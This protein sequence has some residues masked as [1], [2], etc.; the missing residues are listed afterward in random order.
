M[1]WLCDPSDAAD[2]DGWTAL[3][4]L[5]MKEGEFE[6][7]LNFLREAYVHHPGEAKIK[8]KMAVC[9]LKL[10]EEKLAL[11]FLERST[12]GRTGAG[13]RIRILFPQGVA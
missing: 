5:L 1:L 13:H 4:G 12:E 10:G 9:H 7:A 6:K 8:M 3:T 2:L 11:K